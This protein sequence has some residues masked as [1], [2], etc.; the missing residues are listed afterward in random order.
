MAIQETAAKPDIDFVLKT[1]N[2][3][4]TSEYALLLTVVKDMKNSV[5]AV[6][7]IVCAS[8]K[9]ISPCAFALNGSLRLSGQPAQKHSG[10]CAVR[11]R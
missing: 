10:Q 5:L 11:R 6:L 4:R 7:T 3:V 8:D 9:T 2:V 1:N